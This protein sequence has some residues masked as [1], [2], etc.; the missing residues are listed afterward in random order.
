MIIYIENNY[1]TTTPFLRLFSLP[2]PCIYIYIYM[3]VSRKVHRQTKIF[4]WNMTKLDVFFYIAPHTSSI[5]VALLGSLWSKKSPTVDVTSWINFSSHP[6]IYIYIYIYIYKHVCLNTTDYFFF[7]IYKW[8]RS[9]PL[10]ILM[11]GSRWW[12]IWIKLTATNNLT[13]LPKM[14]SEMIESA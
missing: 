13:Q 5:G 3:K 11:Y 14:T 4:S 7:K 8:R 9:S 12:R 6:H 10:A 2:L 1:F